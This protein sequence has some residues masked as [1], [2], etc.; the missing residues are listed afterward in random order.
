MMAARI[1]LPDE[2]TQIASHTARAIASIRAANSAGAVERLCTDWFVWAKNNHVC[3]AIRDHVH[4][5]EVEM[6]ARYPRQK[7]EPRTVRN[8]AGVDD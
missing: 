8:P 2:A 6:S 4:G 7:P 5:V 1:S 3:A